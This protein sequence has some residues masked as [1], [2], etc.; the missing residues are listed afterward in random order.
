MIYEYEELFEDIK[1][2]MSKEEYETLPD[3]EKINLTFCSKTDEELPKLI[4]WFYE[5]PID[6][7]S[8]AAVQVIGAIAES[9]GANAFEAL[10]IL[11]M[12]KNC[13]IKCR[14]EM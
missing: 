4:A 14:E 10:G 5:A 7:R 2:A 13:I 3:E 8:S 6:V 12:A 9:A 1:E 11:E